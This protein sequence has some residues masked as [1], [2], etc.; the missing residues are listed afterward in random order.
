MSLDSEIVFLILV[1]S[2]DPTSSKHY[3]LVNDHIII[4]TL[5]GNNYPFGLVH[6]ASLYFIEF[7]SNLALSFIQLTLDFF[8][9]FNFFGVS[10]FNS[11]KTS[12]C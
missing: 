9:R 7:T 5:F 2:F 6:E 1:D 10:L 11:S 12:I 8:S 4:K 3:S